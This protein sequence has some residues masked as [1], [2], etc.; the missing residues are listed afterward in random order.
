[1]KELL[2]L[3]IYRKLP[4]RVMNVAKLANEM[5]TGHGAYC[6]SA[7]GNISRLLCRDSRKSGMMLIL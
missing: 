4:A 6:G 7:S 1:M 5:P 3:D 2:E